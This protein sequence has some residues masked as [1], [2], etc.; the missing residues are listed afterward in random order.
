[1]FSSNEKIIMGGWSA[2][3]ELA[4]VYQYYYPEQVAGMVFMD[5]YPDYLILGAVAKNASEIEDP[6]TELIANIF[7]VFEPFGL[8]LFFGDNPIQD[9][10]FN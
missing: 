1:L 10:T 2:G 6:H 3:V 9:K 7:R 8:G 5:G 4:L